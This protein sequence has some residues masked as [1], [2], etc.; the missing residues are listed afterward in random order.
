MKLL[1]YSWDSMLDGF[2]LDALKN[3]GHELFV[4]KKKCTDYVRDM[5]LAWEL[6]QCVQKKKIEGMITLNYFPIIS[7]VCDTTGITYYS[8]VYDCPHYTLFAH[9]AKLNC[10]RIFV[11]DR[12]LSM[13][14]KA[15]GVKYVQHFPLAVN[16][17]AFSRT[18]DKR[19]DTTAEKTEVTGKQK[20]HKFSSDISFVGSM[21]T[22]E[23]DYYDQEWFR[24]K[25]SKQEKELLEQYVTAAT[26]CYGDKYQETYQAFLENN[27][28]LLNDLGKR[29]GISLGNDF[30]ANPSEIFMSSVLEKKITVEERRILLSKLAET[31]Y[32]FKLYTGSYL[33][34]A[35][36]AIK[37][38][39]F[40]KGYEV[41][42]MKNQGIVDYQKEM[43][44]VFH[45]SKIN[46]NCTLKS[47]H[48]G[49]PLRVLDIMAC[50]G[51]VLSNNQKEIRDY[52]EVDKEI[53]L[54]DTVEECLEKVMYYLKH[55][56]ERR[57]IAEAGR[58]KILS[59]FSYGEKLPFLFL[60]DN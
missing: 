32:D 38:S 58:Q 16:V 31:N 46:I 8:W 25:L 2:F 15:Y 34:K 28:A 17:E 47:I 36:S 10:N 5:D 56:V 18:I 1:Y 53:V 60:E 37:D 54:Y 27:H 52:F 13:E 4:I 45:N 29:T 7:S 12:E 11:F 6:I 41:L 3:V 33:N 19:V 26:F 59:Q 51:F 40:E 55:E 43:P 22:D 50:G 21:Y 49:I 48:T 44:L 30:Y 23:F 20:Y 42:S 9:Q 14:L 57:K 35:Q 39:V 24:E